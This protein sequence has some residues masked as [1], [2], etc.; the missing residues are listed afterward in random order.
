MGRCLLA[1]CIGVWSLVRKGIIA[2]GMKDVEY[3]SFNTCSLVGKFL[4]VPSPIEEPR[5]LH[6]YQIM[7][8]VEKF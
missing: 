2:L 8:K 7:K 1:R 5:E 3:G 4:I 6:T